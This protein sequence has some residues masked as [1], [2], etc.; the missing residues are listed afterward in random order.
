MKKF[1]P[2]LVMAE[3][4]KGGEDVLQSL[5]KPAP[6]PAKLAAMGDDRFLAMM[7]K[8]IN[9]SGF[10][11]KVIENK[12]PQFEEAFFGFNLKRLQF[13]TIEDWENYLN[14]KRVV[15]HG[16]KIMAMAHNVQYVASIVEQHGSYGQFL[17]DW[18]EADQVGLMWHLKKQAKF[19]GGLTGQMFLRY[20]GKDSFV[21]SR[22]V[23]LAL[24]DAGLDIADEPKSKRDLTKIQNTFN[25]WH[26]E[27]GLPYT[28]LSQI[29]AYSIG[30]NYEASEIA[31][32]SG[33]DAA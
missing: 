30:I 11:W 22:D 5:L 16:R 28:H 12:W 3:K 19:L 29:A 31:A 13:L 32:F 8:A 6:S 27:T 9:Q 18:P 26:D 1:A 15:R 25:A 24:Q 14:D 4:R 10:S 17:A 7:C 33:D 23:V 20:V 21:V 2:I